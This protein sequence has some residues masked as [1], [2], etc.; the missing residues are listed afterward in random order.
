MKKFLLSLML[1]SLGLLMSAQAYTVSVS[2]VVS[3]AN[4]GM[5]IANAAVDVISD[6]AAWGS[7]FNTVLTDNNGFYQDAFMVPAGEYGLLTVG[8][9][10]CFGTW[11]YE[12]TFYAD[13]L[14]VFEFNFEVCTDS[15]GGNGCQAM[16]YYYPEQGP[17]AIQFMDQSIGYPISWYWDF[18]DGATSAVQNPLHNFPDVGEYLVSLTMAGD[19]GCTSVTEQLVW[20]TNDST[21]PGSCQAM[22]TYFQDPVNML[23]VSFVDMSYGENGGPVESWSWDF[24]DGSTSFE[25]NPVHAYNNY[26]I[27]NVC[28][29]ITDSLANCSSTFCMPVEVTGGG[30]GG[31]EAMFYA[32]PD[33]TDYMTMFFVDMSVGTN[34]GPLDSWMWE[35]GDGQS[36]SEQNPLHTYADEG[37]YLVCLTISDSA[38]N[39]LNTT[40]LPVDV[41]DWNNNCLAQFF[42]LPGNDSTPNGTSLGMQ[43]VDASWGNPDSWNWDF[44]DGETSYEQ[45]PFHTYGEEGFYTVCLSIANTADSCISSWCEEVYVR[46]DSIVDCL[47]GYDYTYTTNMEVSFQAWLMGGSDQTAYAWDF[48]DGNSGSGQ[49]VSH[50]FA[51]NGLYMVTLSASDSLTNCFSQ[52]AGLVWIGNDSTWTANIYG[53][54]YLSDSL[55][56]DAADVN[57]MTFDTLGNNVISIATTSIDAN[58]YYEFDLTGLQNCVYFVQAELTA[59]S[60]YFNDYVPTYH[61]DA[62]NW[63]E[64]WPIFPFPAVWGYDVMMQPV[65]FMQTGDASIAGVVDDGESRGVMD[66][67]EILLLN[68]AHH[69]LTY[70]RSEVDGSF[71]FSTLA[72]GTYVV[73]T[74]IT[75]VET[76]PATITLSPEN[77]SSNIVIVVK[78]GQAFL[79]IDDRNSCYIGAVSDIY[80]NPVSENS[81]IEISMKEQSIVH[82]NITNYLGLAVSADEKTFDAGMNQV[83]LS[84]ASLPQG[85]YFVSIQAADGVTMVRKFVKLR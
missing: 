23:N 3:D 27:Y 65:V 70:M 9:A 46:D 80:P 59:A 44:G 10:G 31:C 39:C 77:P 15:T 37:V 35:F 8:T 75:G 48:G 45:N 83:V 71:D 54:V 4:T 26:G 6:S 12:S 66:D 11:L 67:I 28:L 61:L 18:G 51:D 5:P 2:G 13:T 85:L 38:G 73:Y 49:N 29:T 19:S 53:H 33:S 30:G 36:S 82:I 50:V 58:G 1:G 14:S 74:E 32:Y 25:Q 81:S 24:G 62:L 79:G 7:Y 76:S 72:Y 63:T 20:V 52:Y 57:L 22:F 41:M 43:F 47:A 78:N 16:F 56:A 55:M 21:W 68:E 17:F 42:Y 60:A 84:T 64:A 40:C 69:P 34:G